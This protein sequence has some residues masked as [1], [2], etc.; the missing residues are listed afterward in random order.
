MTSDVRR[1]LGSRF[2]LDTRIGSGNY[3]EIYRASDNQTQSLVAIKTLR[4]EHSAEEQALLLFKQEGEAGSA[5]SHE[6]VVKILSHGV[7]DDIHYIVME[8]VRGISLRRRLTLAGRLSISESLRIM[9]AVLRGLQA[10]H[11]AGYVHRDIK[12]Q[13]ILI[14]AQGTPKITDFGIAIC[15]GEPQASP[16]GLTLGTAAYIAPEQA[17]G[18]V[19]GPAAD[20]YSAGAVLFEMLTGEAPFPGDDPIAVMNRHLFEPPRDPRSVNPEISPALAAIV[21]RALAKEPS[22]RFSSARKMHDALELVEPQ[23]DMLSDA[24]HFAPAGNLAWT[25]PL[26]PSRRLP[27]R[28]LGLPA[29]TT[30]VSALLLVVLIIVLM[31]ALVSSLVTA[32]GATG[33]LSS[34]EPPSGLSGGDMPFDDL[35]PSRNGPIARAASIPNWSATAVVGPVAKATESPTPSPSVTPSPTEA[36]SV[37]IA[38]TPQSTA[39]PAEV[40]VSPEPTPSPGNRM[41]SVSTG[42]SYPVTIDD[43]EQSS[44]WVSN[45]SSGSNTQQTTNSTPQKQAKNEKQGQN[46][47]PASPPKPQKK[48]TPKTKNGADNPAKPK[49]PPKKSAPPAPPKPQKPEKSPK[50][51]DHGSKS[52]H[53][54][55]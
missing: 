22:A 44:N 39:T 16:P 8:L 2:V 17:A 52:H 4:P 15:P 41:I 31:L 48:D 33:R 30:F 10:V 46:T 5:I 23:S 35:N 54:H 12:P 18:E 21:T 24:K 20:I 40:A 42:P 37:A 27:A 38:T 28:L 32:R 29:L 14:D 43:T 50:S 51:H 6:N 1:C 13:N 19:T 53:G 9:K 34:S 11:E 45:P 55:G 47:A 36:T 3:A 49:D 7:D 25:V 26:G